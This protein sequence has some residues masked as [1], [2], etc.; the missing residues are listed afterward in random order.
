MAPQELEGVREMSLH[1]TP[2]Y[3]TLHYATLHYTTVL[4]QHCR[5][6]STLHYTTLHHRV[7][8]V[9]HTGMEV[10]HIVANV[11]AAALQVCLSI[12]CILKKTKNCEKL[13]F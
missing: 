9:G 10:G 6:Q 4:V 2:H 5:L 8:P 12:D 7:I 3:T 11:T 13:Q 1:T